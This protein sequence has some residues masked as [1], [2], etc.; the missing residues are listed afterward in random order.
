MEEGAIWDKLSETKKLAREISPEDSFYKYLH[1]AQLIK[2]ILGLT[3][4]YGHAKYRLLLLW[5]DVPGE[6]GCKHRQEINDFANIVS[7]DNI[8]FHSQSCQE[9]ISSLT[10][11]RDQHPEYVTYL[12]SRYL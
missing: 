7:S 2:H 11:H 6:A 10:K 3:L 5:Y 12:T 8:N 9:M 1:A 4:K